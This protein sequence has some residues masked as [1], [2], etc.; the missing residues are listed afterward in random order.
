MKSLSILAFLAVTLTACQSTS[1]LSNTNTDSSRYA[2]GSDKSQTAQIRTALAGQ[3]I[4]ERRLDD[5][6]TQLELAFRADSRYA[7][8]G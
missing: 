3:Y 1:N 2:I 7:W 8:Q 5:A 4:S 6:K